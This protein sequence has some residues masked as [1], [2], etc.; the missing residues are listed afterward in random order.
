ME[1]S[2]SDSCLCRSPLQKGPHWR[3]VCAGARQGVRRF[4]FTPRSYRRDRSSLGRG[5]IFHPF[6]YDGRPPPPPPVSS[7]SHTCSPLGACLFSHMMCSAVEASHLPRYWKK[8]RKGAAKANTIS[9]GK[10]KKKNLSARFMNYGENKSERPAS[11]WFNEYPRVGF[12]L[13][14]PCSV[15]CRPVMF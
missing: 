12:S 15:I 9:E 1:M 4:P 3:L 10:K 13:S 14:G 2:L 6:S 11:A 8:R 7:P 5:S